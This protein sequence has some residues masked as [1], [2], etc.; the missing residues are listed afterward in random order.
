MDDLY[1]AAG[2]TEDEA[3]APDLDE[4]DLE[5]EDED[6]DEEDDVV[7]VEDRPTADELGDDGPSSRTD[8]EAARLVALNMALNGQA[9]AATDRYL[10]ENFDLRNRKALLDEVYATVGG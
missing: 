1:V 5:D 2:R 6:G 10:A 4:A 3:A 9:R 8:I 7:E